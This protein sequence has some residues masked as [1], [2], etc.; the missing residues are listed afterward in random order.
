MNILVDAYL[1]RNLGDD[2]MLK[3]V[4]LAFPEH[5][6]LLE[7]ADRALLI[8][9]EGIANL[10]PYSGQE[11]E[12]L[13]TVGG[14]IFELGSTKSIINRYQTTVKTH[15]HYAKQGKRLA[16]IGCNVGAVN[17]RLTGMVIKAQLRH[18]GRITVRD[19]YSLKALQA[20]GLECTCY[21]DLLFGCALPRTPAEKRQGLAISV[22]RST[23]DRQLNYTCYKKYAEIADE[24]ISAAGEAVTMLAFDCENEND[25]AAAYTI[26]SMMKLKDM[27]KIVVHTGS[28]EPVLRAISASRAIVGTRFHSII[29]G[30]LAGVPILP[31]CYA[32]KSINL[33]DEL[34]YGLRLGFAE[35]ASLNAGETA[36]AII[37]GEGL[38]TL[39]E[40]KLE[41]L[42]SGSKGHIEAL[43]AY[44]S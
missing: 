35:L 2:L 39:T 15:R 22:Y 44:L 25:I 34:G 27:C 21:P 17:R 1:D 42:R 33:L 36:K 19:A 5:S 29:F 4:A 14:S 41:E 16:T 10:A 13:L 23:R 7:A 18:S 8:P 20:M 9:F 3:A 6:F 37:K 24:Y 32:N 43:K 11:F 30:L 26:K 28:E 12:A 38:L 31:V 40:N